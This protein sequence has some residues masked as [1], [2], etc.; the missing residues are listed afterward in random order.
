LNLAKSKFLSLSTELVRKFRCRTFNLGTS[1]SIGPAVFNKLIGLMMIRDEQDMLA[2]ALNNHSMFCRAIFV[3]DGSRGRARAETKRILGD[4]SVVAGYWHDDDT[5]YEQPLRDGARQYL[6]ERSRESHGLNNWYA[7]L[8]GDELWCRDP[9]ELLH[10]PD[11]ACGVL[12]Q[13]YHF[14]PHKSERDTWSYPGSG[15]IEKSSRWYMMP[16]GKERRLFYDTG[17]HNYVPEQH[18]TTV[19]PNLPELTLP[20]PIKQYNYRTPGQAHHRAANR[21]ATGWQENHY[22]HLVNDAQK[23][24]VDTLATKDKRWLQAIPEGQGQITN[25]TANPFPVLIPVEVKLKTELKAD[26]PEPC[27]ALERP[28]GNDSSGAQSTAPIDWCE[29][30]TKYRDIGHP[31]VQGWLRKEVFGALQ[32]VQILHDQFEISGGVAEI[33]VYHGAFFLALDQ[34]RRPGEKALAMDV[35]SSQRLNIDHSGKGDRE[36]FVAN[37]ERYGI[38]PDSVEICEVDSTTLMP[39][40]VLEFLGGQRPRLFSID[41]GHTKEHVFSDLSIAEHT[42]CPGGIVFVDDYMHPAWPG[43]T[44]GLHRWMESHVKL[45]PFAWVGRKLLLTTISQQ[46]QM[47]EGFRE[48]CSLIPAGR[49]KQTVLFGDQVSVALPDWFIG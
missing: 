45:R 10:I 6:L 41:G 3:L 48:H 34:I 30:L 44:E 43:V 7:V 13:L 35:F 26:I 12:T 20:I 1:P 2:E 40:E 16:P 33:G 32:V 4:F 15:S 38:D 39:E 23:F 27:E 37:L 11:E 49:F 14:F 21:K 8:H 28:S 29:R 5:G 36:A 31:N 46:K 17:T 42:I 47:Y 24:F 18:R 9:R 22:H 25:T 19:P